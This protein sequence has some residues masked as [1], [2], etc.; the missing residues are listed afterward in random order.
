MRKVYC[1]D[2]EIREIL[3]IPKALDIAESDVQLL[4]VTG[5]TLLSDIVEWTQAIYNVENTILC[6]CKMRPGVEDITV[7]YLSSSFKHI[8]T[9]LSEALDAMIRMV[10]EYYVFDRRECLKGIL[11]SHDIVLPVSYSAYVD[12]IERAIG[13]YG[14]L[15]SLDVLFDCIKA[16]N[17]VYGNFEKMVHYHID[18]YRVV[19]DAYYQYKNTGSELD[20]FRIYT[21]LPIEKVANKSDIS[22]V[23]MLLMPYKK[24]DTLTSRLDDIIMYCYRR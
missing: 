12:E 17:V 16:K 18:V 3:D 2:L 24:E 20:V 4:I 7:K 21:K 8:F 14:V 10:P 13:K 6:C 11:E 22:F 19:S 9:N 1:N 15:I 5:S 23:S